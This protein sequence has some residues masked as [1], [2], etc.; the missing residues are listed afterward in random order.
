MNQP[1]AI[2]SFSGISSLGNNPKS[3]WNE[4]KNNS[5][6]FTKIK[7]LD[8][9]WG[10]KVNYTNEELLNQIP[11]DEKIYEKLDRTVLFALF[12]ASQLK[13][14]DSLKDK[15]IGVNISSSRGATELWEKYHS[16]SLQNENFS[17][18]ASPTT[19]LGNISSWIGQFLQLNGISFSHSMT[20]SSALISILNGIAWM[21]ANMC[22]AMIVGGSEAPLT[23]FTINQMNAL[24]I[25]SKD[26]DE[27]PCKAGKLGKERNT[28]ILGEGAGL[29]ILE[30]NPVGKSLCYIKGF[31]FGS[32][33]IR[34]AVSL[35]K[36]ACNLQLAY[37]QIFEKFPKEEI[38]VI[39][40]HTPGTIKGDLA[41]IEA[42]KAT[43]PDKIPYLIN[44]KWKLGHTF[45]ASGILSLE[46]AILMLQN[47]EVI[48]NPFYANQE[49]PKRIQNIL[50]N[51]M[52]FGGNAISILV[53]I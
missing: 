10:S 4:Y 43:F 38:D 32:E 14:I 23:P 36:N 12:C 1:I 49:K 13:D 42:I 7:E 41:E 5:H 26:E 44:N 17:L 53:G 51:S 45:G 8:Y 40:T 18:L 20:C 46:L 24:K 47:L 35:S 50:I 22:D 52:G 15:I 21:N 37:K 2:T 25:Y 33:K 11:F 48:E 9:N 27:F 19:S 6:F 3:V 29:C 34:N 28:M 30:K 31:G 39:I 16:Q